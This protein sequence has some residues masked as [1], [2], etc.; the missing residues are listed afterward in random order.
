M[1]P[2]GFLLVGAIGGVLGYLIFAFENYFSFPVDTG[3]VSVILVGVLGRSLFNREIH[4]IKK[5][6]RF[7]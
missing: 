6:F 5:N 4:I 3:A 1:I 2:K 7:F